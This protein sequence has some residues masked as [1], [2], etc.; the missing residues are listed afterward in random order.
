MADKDPPQ[1]SQPALT[2]SAVEEV[3]QGAEQ[4][5]IAELARARSEDMLGVLVDAANAN[6]KT[7]DDGKPTEDVPSWAVR[8]NAAKTV[9]EIGHG[10]APTQEA[11]K[12]DG[13]L[14]ITVNKLFMPGSSEKIIQPG[15]I[16]AEV[17]K[18]FNVTGA[19]ANLAEDLVEIVPVLGKPPEDQGGEP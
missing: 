11:E 7:D 1:T 10:R 18:T 13:G 16:E 12:N 19:K 2:R 14:H 3:M 8:T 4:L 17:S 15:E 5:D 6:V 9:I